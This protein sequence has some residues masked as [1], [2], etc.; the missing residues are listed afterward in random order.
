MNAT[1]RANTTRAADVKGFGSGFAVPVSG[2]L[3][4]SFVP[5][6][7]KAPAG[8]LPE[9]AKNPLLARCVELLRS[10]PARIL[11]PDGEDMRAVAAAVRLRRE[12]LAYPVL[13][14]CPLT[15]R[16]IA[17]EYFRRNGGAVTPLE[18][19]DPSSPALLQR[20]LAEYI[21]LA[22]GQG[23]KMDDSEAV[24]FALTGLGAGAL[25]VRLGDGEIGIGGNISPTS[26]TLR[27]GLRVFGTAPGSRTVSGFFFMVAPE[28]TGE[29]G[30]VLIFA[31]GGVIP[32]PTQEQLADIAID[33]ARQFRRMTGD[34]PRVAMLSFS[35]C[36]S[37]KHPRA[38]FVRE[39]CA[40]VRQRAPGLVVDGEL[41]FDAAVNPAVADKKS[42]GSP[43]GGR[44]NVLVF[45]SLEAGN[46]GYKIAQ[47][48]G[49]YLALGPLLQGLGGGWHDL[50]RGCSADDIYQIALVGTVLHRE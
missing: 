41:Q 50:S 46:I 9:S 22:A 26:D 40:L 8:A 16:K 19:A 33:S 3:F 24:R 49:G 14:G 10:K 42:P 48:L 47:Y 11:L 13:V 6:A 35:T 29:G 31:D 20:N 32:E 4:P 43:L 37:A 30:R 44:A 1:L 45:P 34:E 38:E 7:Q 27:A 5:A 15:I 21:R 25:M 2:A 23:K 39:A 28:H 12:G 18:I 36:G 17:Q